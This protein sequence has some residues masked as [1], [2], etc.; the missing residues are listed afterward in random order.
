MHRRRGAFC[1]RTIDLTQN[2]EGC[3]VVAL[4][5]ELDLKPTNLQKQHAHVNNRYF[6]LTFEGHVHVSHSGRISL[7]DTAT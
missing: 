7:Q 4:L 1:Q 3:I 2:G 6:V 5:G